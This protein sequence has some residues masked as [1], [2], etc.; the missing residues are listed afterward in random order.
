MLVESG[1]GSYFGRAF[2]LIVAFATIRKLMLERIRIV[3]R[4]LMLPDR[5]LIA[6]S[7]ARL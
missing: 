1:V 3:D 6:S 7:A 5:S 2:H 4:Y